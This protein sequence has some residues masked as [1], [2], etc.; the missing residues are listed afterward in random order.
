MKKR[1]IFIALLVAASLTLGVAPAL[2][3]DDSDGGYLALGDSVPFGFNPLVADKSN[4]ANFVGY[5]EA[6]ARDEERSVVNASCPGETSG[7]LIS[8]SA[9]DNG[10]TFF[11]FVAGFPLHAAYTGAQLAFATAY[12]QSHPKTRLISIT[13]G[14]N[15]LFL[16][17]KACA[18]KDP[19]P[20]K[21]LACTVAGLPALLTSLSQ[22]LATIYGTLRAA[23]YHGKLVAVTYYALDYANALEVSVITALDGVTAAVTRQFGGVVAD[24]F[25]A[26]Q[27]PAAAS[28]GNSCAA[29]LLIVVSASPLIC[30]VHPSPK[31]RDVLAGALE[32]AL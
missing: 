16:L 20:A 22:N 5:P 25:A 4:P 12:V 19:A 30:D 14:A 7:S 10:C 15:D 6:F 2:A 8:R 21:V 27:A 3:A 32:E 1:S 29:G 18:A 9:P 26:F 11:R 23:G 13:V 28:G 24:G 31:G 17:Q